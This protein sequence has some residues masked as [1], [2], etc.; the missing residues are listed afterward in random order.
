[1][2]FVIKDKI[3]I[4]DELMKGNIFDPEAYNYIYNKSTS[5]IDGDFIYQDHM[6]L[7]KVLT[8]FNKLDPDY[9]ELLHYVQVIKIKVKGNEKNKN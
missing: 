7:E 5:F 1:M 6:Q 3:E 4:N 2:T 9:L 8:N